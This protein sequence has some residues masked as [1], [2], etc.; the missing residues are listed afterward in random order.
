MF[1]SWECYSMLTLA[2]EIQARSRE[3]KTDGYSMSIGELRSLY[4]SGDLQIHPSFQRYF[5]WNR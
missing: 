3:I 4:E 1:D 5:R 2:D